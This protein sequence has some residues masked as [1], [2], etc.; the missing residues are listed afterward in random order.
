MCVECFVFVTCNMHI[1]SSEAR[2][3]DEDWSAGERQQT[4]RRYS[5][6]LFSHFD[7]RRTKTS[8]GAILSG[9][10]PVRNR[11]NST[12]HRRER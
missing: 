5:N 7:V 8:Q 12:L 11:L 9:V 3:A 1:I 6:G 2:E 4:K 10:Q